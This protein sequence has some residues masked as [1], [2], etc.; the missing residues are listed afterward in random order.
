SLAISGTL[1]ATIRFAVHSTDKT[2]GGFGPNQVA[3]LLGLA[4]LLAF[5]FLLHDKTTPA[6]KGVL[7]ASIFVFATQSAM[8]FSRGGLYAA[9]GAAMLAAIFLL[10]AKQGAAR[11]VLLSPVLALVTIYGI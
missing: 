6:L 11:L 1:A 2:S 8:T 5:F 4:A 9:A 3:A 10:R 7:L